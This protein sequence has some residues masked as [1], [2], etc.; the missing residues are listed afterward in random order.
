MLARVSVLEQ[1][2]EV[3]Q[4]RIHELAKTNKFSLTPYSMGSWS[5][6]KYK[7]LDKCSLKFLLDYILKIS[8]IEPDEHTD[9]SALRH[10]GTAAHS[11]L[12][13]CIQGD[14][15]DDAYEKAKVNHLK[16]VTETYWPNVENL[17]Y[18]IGEFLLRLQQFKARNQV[19]KVYPELKLAVDKDWKPVPFFS[20]KA[21]FRGVVDLPML[22]ENDDVIIID[23]K[24]GGS[25]EFGLRNYQEQL[26]SYKAL[27]HFGQQKIEG[28][29]S[30]IHFIKEGDI[31]LGRRV[32]KS[33]IEDVPSRIQVFIE[34]SINQV[35]DLGKFNYSRN[36][37]CSYCD[38]KEICH[39]GKRGTANKLQPVIELSGELLK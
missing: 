11:I 4:E 22:L 36:S 1:V 5:P 12:E 30:G 28:A 26:D 29:A 24:H 3:A 39:N 25:P 19:R 31:L 18:N 15:L 33:Y 17:R 6:S 10:I 8:V 20:P 27:F 13:F 14:S 21:Y 34:G 32:S 9:D 35:N 16:D 38:Y 23:H 2:P 7:S 37:L